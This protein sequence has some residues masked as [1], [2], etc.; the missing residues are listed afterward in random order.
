MEWS[1]H[2]DRFGFAK[3]AA[4]LMVAVGSVAFAETHEY[5]WLGVGRNARCGRVDRVF[6]RYI[7]PFLP[8]RAT[9]MGYGCH[10]G[11]DL[12]HVY[13]CSREHLGPPPLVVL[14]RPCSARLATTSASVAKTRDMPSADAAEARSQPAARATTSLS[15]PQLSHW[16]DWQNILQLFISNLE[17]KDT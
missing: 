15:T 11:W 4:A 8:R 5:F 6:A 17:E 12:G 16:S 13:T 3:F 9:A 14:L 7:A 1:C 2:F 10:R